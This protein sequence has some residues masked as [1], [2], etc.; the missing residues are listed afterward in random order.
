MAIQSFASRDVEEFFYLSR[1]P[2]KAGWVGVFKVARRKLD[3]VHYAGKLLDLQAPP[4]NQLEALK[5][6]LTGWHSIRINDQFR[7]IFRWTGMG[8]KDVNIIDYH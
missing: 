1:L 6:D 3:L 2:R 4:G 8:P 5:G 7:V